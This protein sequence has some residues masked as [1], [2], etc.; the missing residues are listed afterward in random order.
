MSDPATT[1]ALKA[2]VDTNQLALDVG[3]DLTKITEGMQV[4]AGLYVHYATQTV[5]A[6]RQYERQKSHLE[7]LEA[8]LDKHFRKTLINEEEDAKGKLVKKKPTEPQIRAAIVEDPRWIA[9]NSR[10]L[11]AQEIYR[12]A[13]VA[14]R[15]F[16]HRKDM[17]LQIAK[18]A[19]REA[20]GQLRVAQN[21]SNRERLLTAMQEKQ[22]G[23]TD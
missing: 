15:S 18:D 11:D 1:P 23:S 17:L 10:M 3:I 14:E 16:E 8:K 13:E 5:K 9:L 2:Y 6:K 12:L 20:E 4:Q 19:A 21:Q 22:S 7:I